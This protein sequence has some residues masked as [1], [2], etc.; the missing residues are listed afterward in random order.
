MVRVDLSGWG[1]WLSE[2]GE[3]DGGVGRERG[4]TFACLLSLLRT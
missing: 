2:G 3:G 4:L 1:G